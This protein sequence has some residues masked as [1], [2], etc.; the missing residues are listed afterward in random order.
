MSQDAKF[1]LN[2]RKNFFLVRLVKHWNWLLR[3]VAESPSLDVFKRHVGAA[4]GVIVCWVYLVRAMSG[5]ADLESIFQC[6]W[7][8]DSMKFLRTACSQNTS[9]GIIQN[10]KHCRYLK[11]LPYQS[12]TLTKLSKMLTFHDIWLNV[13]KYLRQSLFSKW[14]SCCIKGLSNSLLHAISLYVAR[15]DHYLGECR[16]GGKIWTQ[17]FYTKNTC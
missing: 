5:L 8:H 11:V 9:A 17:N 4:L 1:R 13:L 7:F 3:E 15:Y 10:S 6:R 16:R 14:E 2:I 12:L